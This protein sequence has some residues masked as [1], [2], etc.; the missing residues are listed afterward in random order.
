MLYEVITKE[1]LL[2]LRLWLVWRQLLV[3]FP[4]RRE[5]TQV[6][7]VDV[8]IGNN[9]PADGQVVIFFRVILVHRIKFQTPFAAILHCFIQESY[10]FV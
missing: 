7:V 5:P 2:G 9:F 10:N 6:A 1:R 4:P 8:P 3:N